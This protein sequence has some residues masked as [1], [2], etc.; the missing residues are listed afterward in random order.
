M[1]LGGGEGKKSQTEIFGLRRRRKTET[2]KE[3]NVW[4]RRIALAQLREAPF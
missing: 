2:E 4:R 1:V 3:E